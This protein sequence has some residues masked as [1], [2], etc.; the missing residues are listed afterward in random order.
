MMRTTA[1]AI[2][3]ILL[4][5]LP[6]P[7]RAQYSDYDWA[8]ALHKEFEFDDMAESILTDMVEG[9]DR[10]ATERQQ[11]RLGLAELRA[12]QAREEG[13]VDKR[14]ELFA[15][16]RDIMGQ[17]IKQ[18]PDKDTDAY[19]QAVFA[20]KDVL[21]ERGE[22]ALEASQKMTYPEDRR[23][24]YKD[25]ANNDF[26]KAEIL[27][28]D[29]MDRYEDV[30]LGES[31]TS[32]RKWFR[33]ARAWYDLCYLSYQK[34]LTLQKVDQ[35]ETLI[36]AARQTEDFILEM[37]RDDPRAM[38]I[39][40]Y[41]YLLA[42]R[43]QAAM[44][45]H[46]SA[47]SFYLSVTENP[48]V[49]WERKLEP[50][51][52]GLME[53]AYWL[54]LSHLNDRQRYEDTV[55]YGRAMVERWEKLDMR[56]G[57]RGRGAYVQLAEALFRLGSTNEALDIATDVAETGSEDA[58][59]VLANRLIAEI[60][61]ATPDKSRFS[62]GVIL[63]AAQGAWSRGEE[64]RD[65][66]VRYYRILL[67]VVDQ[68]EDE[69]ARADAGGEAW[70][71]LAYAAYRKDQV[72]RAA[73]LAREGA[74][75]HTA[76]KTWA[77]ELVKLWERGVALFRNRAG[78]ESGRR[79]V[80]ECQSWQL[81]NAGKLDMRISQGE[82]YYEQAGQQEAK[83]ERL[84]ES[85]NIEAAVEAYEEAAALYGKS[86]EAGGPDKERAMTKMARTKLNTGRI[87]LERGQNA[88][89]VRLMEEAKKDFHAYL[90]FARDPRN[91]LTRADFKM[92][93]E[94]AVAQAR[95]FI[96]RANSLLDNVVEDPGKREALAEETVEVLR[97]FADD[98]SP[99]RQKS[100]VLASL[101]LRLF[102]QLDLGHVEDARSTYMRMRAIDPSADNTR[103][104]GA[105]VAK[106]LREPLKEE[107]EELT[108]GV[109]P[110]EPAA[111]AEVRE[112]PGFEE[113][114]AELMK[115]NNLYRDWLK[116][117]KKASSDPTN[118]YAI[119]KYYWDLAAWPQAAEL[120][121]EALSRF[122]NS[123]KADP[124]RLRFMRYWLLVALF[125]QA[126]SASIEGDTDKAARLWREAGE[127]AD[128]LLEADRKV[129]ADEVRRMAAIIYGGFVHDAPGRP[130]TW[131]PA[132]GRY[133]K[134]L[135]LWNTIREI[136][137]AKGQSDDTYYEA[138]FYLFHTAFRKRRA[139]GE[140]ID[141]IKK[142]IEQQEMVIGFGGPK[143]ERYYRWL[144]DEML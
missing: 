104:G 134:A 97:G 121:Q 107:W 86:A 93:R 58:S 28:T 142:R 114:R 48:L 41:G 50:A 72:L 140:P 15:R 64:F 10:T 67:Q 23:Q 43:I 62:P 65:E 110:D 26:L 45:N 44:E 115:V 109:D 89:A 39:A 144:K 136:S 88:E 122:N 124:K 46:D 56:F 59:G 99:E 125:N 94:D 76:S 84:A 108:G 22:A 113:L 123:A 132:T 75:R 60:I 11:G 141:D 14:L 34:A 1:I 139:D 133:D 83:A 27:L 13:D 24:K 12:S 73:F 143:W 116:S 37:E 119:S 81:A 105:V 103:K 70:Y 77:P 96:A 35:L 47:M 87:Y 19:Y 106:R 20:Y 69:A 2:P 85:G 127:L 25:E 111:W 9:S 7:A 80:Q 29:I 30:T 52:Q 36:E 126:K 101:L 31:E 71:R 117:S 32:R 137:R 8:M 4:L 95:Y 78:T 138:N 74:R 3:V 131:Y 38:L 55:K 102:A 79:L 100:L 61:A 91:E 49:I 98:H 129:S 33:R 5:V 16:A 82:I 135:E 112:K 68:I 128:R 57:S 92:A 17:A 18:W 21:Q 6:A 118:W 120:L 51:V 54:L 90:E 40:L 66:A 42:G 53:R 63:S 130:I